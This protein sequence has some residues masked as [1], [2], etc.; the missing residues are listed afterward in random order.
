MNKLL[1]AL[2]KNENDSL[3]DLTTNKIKATNNKILRELHLPNELH[4]EYMRKLENYKYVD[5]LSDLRSGSYIRWIPISNP[6][7][8]VLKKGSLFCDI[9]ATDKGLVLVCKGAYNKH[10]QLNFDENLIFQKLSDQELVLLSA[11]DHL[12]K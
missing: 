1:K 12:A 4:I 3:L 5:E 8:L 6:L 11:L 7:Y 10:F 9:K 2:E